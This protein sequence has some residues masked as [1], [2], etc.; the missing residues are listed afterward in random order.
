MKRRVEFARLLV[1][2][3]ELLLLDE[4][5]VGLDPA[6]WQL[7]D[8]LVHDVVARGGAAVLVAHEEDRVRPLVDRVA[9]VVDGRI[10]ERA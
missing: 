7:V 5:H 3:P 6:A 9:V 4:A 2:E 10:E 1:T 8:H